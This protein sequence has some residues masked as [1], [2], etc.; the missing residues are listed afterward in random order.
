MV[1]DDNSVISDILTWPE[2]KMAQFV[3]FQKAC[4]VGASPGTP[5]LQLGMAGAMCRANRPDQPDLICRTIGAA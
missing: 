4:D 2:N 1:A 3:H 5:E